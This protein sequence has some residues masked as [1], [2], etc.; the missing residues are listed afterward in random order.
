MKVVLDTNVI[1]SAF[2]TRGLC[3]DVFEVCLMS[4]AIVLSE[5]ILSEVKEKLIDKINLPKNTV[6]EIIDYLRE[7]AQIVNPKN[8]RE[9]ICKDKSDIPIIGT[10]LSG[11]ARF[12][13]TG[14]D[15]LLILKRYKDVEI[16]TLREFWNRLRH[17]EYK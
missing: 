5:Y 9:P 6:Q 13:I 1:V 14:D 2:A 4:H 8:I 17:F 7:Q 11:N 10:A 15:D 3:A 12:I 16:L